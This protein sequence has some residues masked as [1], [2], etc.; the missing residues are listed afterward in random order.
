MIHTRDHKTVNIFDHWQYL[1]P[2]RRK[3]LDESWAGLFR[4]HILNEL[5]VGKIAPYF[6]KDFGRPTK[7]LYTAIGAIV[8]QQ[9]HDFSDEETVDELCFNTQWHFALDISDESDGAKYICAKTLWN[10]RKII[11]DHEL[12]GVIFDNI[13]G[14]LAD[15]FGVD[16]S[17]QRLDSVHI[18][19][20]M[21]RLGRMGIFV[22][23]IKKFLVNLKRQH[24]ELFDELK[25]ELVEKYLN[26]KELGC[27][28]FV[29]PSETEKRLS[30]VA[31][32]LFELI[33]RF[34][35][36]PDVTGMS[37]FDLLIRVFEDQCEVSEATDDLPEQVSVR[38]AKEVG[39]DSLQN[40][41][42]PEATYDGHK[43]QG[44]Q[45]QIMETFSEEEDQ[46]EKDKTLNLITHVETEPAHQSDA[47]ALLPAIESAIERNLPPKEVL[48]DSLYGSDENIEAAREKGVEVVA[49]TMGKPGKKDLDLSDFEFS[50]KGIVTACPA[51]HAPKV[52]GYRT[53]LYLWSAL[54]ARLVS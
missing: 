33:K 18:K 51:S 46:A 43:G 23:S 53:A 54:G 36:N 30:E 4:E 26:K 39:S 48:A 2:K 41:S 31:E 40:P 32:D 37:S 9:A 8:L 19:S 5:P 45:V 29:K 15:V 20:N 6:H 3:L 25:P 14:K 38:P 11:T 52:S 10:L 35:D 27:F 28:S 49:P 42:D 24:R 34:S 7:E 22:K 13:T 47:N 17:K 12:D 21:R 16:T 1:G 50:Q 44:Y